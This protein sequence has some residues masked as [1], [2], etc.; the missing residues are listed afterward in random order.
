VTGEDVVAKKPAPD[1]F[2]KA[3]DK[4]GLRP[5]QC[6]VLED[7]VNGIQAAL[8]AGMRCVTVAQSFPAER[9]KAAH[10]T[11][12]RIADVSMSDLLGVSVN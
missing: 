6:V 8:S 9:L 10:V 4:L 7:A 1:I 2:L 11:R 5:G 12:P 3:A